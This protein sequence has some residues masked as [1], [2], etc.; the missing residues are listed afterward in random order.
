MTGVHIKVSE[1]I[2]ETPRRKPR[3]ETDVLPI[4]SWAAG[5]LPHQWRPPNPI[6]PWV[7]ESRRMR[8]TS[9][10]LTS[11]CAYHGAATAVRRRA[12]RPGQTQTNADHGP[13]E[14]DHHIQT[15]HSL[16][17]FLARRVDTSLVGGAEEPRMN[18]QTPKVS[19]K[20]FLCSYII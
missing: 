15:P 13:L 6:T 3:R 19:H 11:F 2:P 9:A 16:L 18:Q 5:P 4:L 20:R 10:C 8:V 7:R 17:D 1:L 12:D 14:G